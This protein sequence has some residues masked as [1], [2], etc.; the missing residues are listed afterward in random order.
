[1][2]MLV[3]GAIALGLGVAGVVLA[4]DAPPPTYT[5]I[6]AAGQ[7]LKGRFNADVGKVR[8]VALVA[9]T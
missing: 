9:P 3:L 1:M 5:T 8:I 2:R 7:P 4:I 6:D